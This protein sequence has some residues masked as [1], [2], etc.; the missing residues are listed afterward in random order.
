MTQLRVLVVSLD[1]LSRAGL[2]AVLDQQPELTVMGQVSGDEDSFL[3]L[4]VYGPDV[5]VWDVSW[6]TTPAVHNL[7]LLPENSPP[8]RAVAARA[9]AGRVERSRRSSTCPDDRRS[10]DHHRVVGK[11]DR[12]H[13][14]ICPKWLSTSATGGGRYRTDV[15][16]GG[17]TLH[18]GR[19][20]THA[21]QQ[22][23]AP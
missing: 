3:P 18:C 5:V 12:A 9:P 14:G 16:H 21:A 1:L 23:E 19:Y 20:I 17:W 7:A 15:R 2:A 4:D 22:R 10:R 8:V 6:A 11:M 13:S